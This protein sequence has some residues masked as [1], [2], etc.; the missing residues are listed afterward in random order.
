MGCPT[1]RRSHRLR[2]W[3]AGSGPW[4]MASSSASV[5]QCEGS[6]ASGGPSAP[7][8]PWDP[9]A[10][11]PPAWTDPRSCHPCCPSSPHRCRCWWCCRGGSG[12]CCTMTAHQGWAVASGEGTQGKK[13]GHTPTNAN[14]DAN[15]DANRLHHRH[16]P[17]SSPTPSQAPAAC[18]HPCGSQQGRWCFSPASCPG[19][20]QRQAVHGQAQRCPGASW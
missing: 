10:P 20:Q 18:R 2:G 9:R 12:H 17:G 13:K 16:P 5:C 6:R 15:W 7:R 11:H 1:P 3:L 19:V 4:L 14:W 8:C